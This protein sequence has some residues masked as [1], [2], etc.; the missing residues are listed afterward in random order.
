MPEPP[1]MQA[2]G[3]MGKPGLRG[4]RDGHRVVVGT[5]YGAQRDT[6]SA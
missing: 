1:A 6:A 5:S 2:G 4:T 3:Q